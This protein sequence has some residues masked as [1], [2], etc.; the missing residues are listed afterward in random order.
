M[1]EVIYDDPN[2]QVQGEEWPKDDEDDKINIHVE[3]VFI[4]GLLV[5]L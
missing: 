2:E 1:V 4:Y 3:A 5:Y